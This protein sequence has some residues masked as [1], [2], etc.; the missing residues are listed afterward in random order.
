MV[1]HMSAPPSSTGLTILRARHLFPL[2][3][4]APLAWGVA[5]AVLLACGAPAEEP[6]A[7]TA[8][9]LKTPTAK[10]CSGSTVTWLQASPG[11]DNLALA[12]CDT[13]HQAYK[14]IEANCSSPTMVERPSGVP[15]FYASCP[16]GAY[17]IPADTMTSA[18]MGCQL[19]APV[20]PD[21]QVVTWQHEM[22]PIP[23]GCVGARCPPGIGGP[24]T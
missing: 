3:T 5:T 16:A 21:A 11:C 6:S 24:G 12:Y 15:W 13:V 17:A 8:E 23:G 20:S 2:A 19:P 14:Q 10:A 7:E 18:D 22:A 1:A 4:F 9:A